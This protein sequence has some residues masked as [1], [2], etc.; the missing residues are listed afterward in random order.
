MI[1][2]IA[3]FWLLAVL[4]Q[5]GPAAGEDAF[6][7]RE[8]DLSTDT[9]VAENLLPSAV[10]E[11]RSWWTIDGRIRSMLSSQTTYEFG[12]PP[13]EPGPPFAPL[14]RL[15]WPLDSVWAGLRFGIERPTWD[16]TL[17]WLTPIEQGIHG[18]MVDT[19]WSLSDIDNL[20]YSRERWIDGQ[21]LDLR[22]DFRLTERWFNLP[23]E[24]WPAAGFR[25]QRF[26]IMAHDAQNVF[27]TEYPITGDVV[28]FNQQYYIGYLGVELRS[29]FNLPLT[30]QKINL[31]FQ[32]DGGAAWGY[33]IDHHL[34]YEPTT[35]RY[36]MES[37]SGGAA[38]VGLIAETKIFQWL[39]AGFQADYMAI[40]TVGTHRW[41]MYGQWNADETWSNGVVVKSE[42]A[43]V[44]AFLRARF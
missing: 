42:Q 1:V 20:S 11:R 9:A 36:T 41:L 25:F 22:G 18:R 2:R 40:Y 17:E 7:S 44:T 23:L 37:T 8:P 39:S 31:A 14:S 30:R 19:D 5:A 6:S 34:T 32:A 43:S 33:N 24:I 35:H 21:M 28:S 29:G 26:S 27:P 13:S 4:W 3:K 15:Q 38:H 16:L 12:M 10:E